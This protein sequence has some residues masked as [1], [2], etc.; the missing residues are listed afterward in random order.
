MSDPVNNFS[1]A[2]RFEEMLAQKYSKELAS[3]DLTDQGVS[4]VGAK[5]VKIPNAIMGGY[6]P[7]DRDGGF[8]RGSVTLSHTLK[9]LEYDRSVEFFVD[10]MDVDET[11]QAATA[12]KLTNVFL[13]EQ[14]I[15]ELDAYRF[16]TLH[17]RYVAADGRPDSTALTA[18]NVLLKFDQ[19]MEEMDEA[20]AP[21]DG[22]ILYV[23][24]R[25]NSL[26]KNAVGIYRTFGVQSGA[27]AVDRA[28]ASLDNVK[29]VSVPAGRMR[30]AYNFSDGFTPEGDQIN[31]ILLHPSA[32]IAVQK[33]SA[34]YLWP[35]GSHQRG[36]GWLYQNRR[37]GDLFIFNEKKDGI[38]MNVTASSPEPPEEPDQIVAYSLAA[39]GSDGVSTTE[40]AITLSE[41]VTLTLA[42]I[43]VKGYGDAGVTVGGLTG[44]D[45]SYV[46]GITTTQNDKKIEINI[47][48]VEGYEFI[49]S[50]NEVTV[51]YGI[52]PEPDEIVAFTASANG[53]S[54]AVATTAITVTLSEKVAGLTAAKFKL[55]SEAANTI[56]I[57]GATTADE[58]G[59]YTLAVTVAEDDDAKD[60]TLTIEDVTGYE[61][62][63]VGNVFKVYYHA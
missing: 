6:K 56:A 61:F 28:V 14:A 3:S 32:V 42:N 48:N 22:R 46:L 60:I 1:Y 24:P 44:S 2:T 15:P 26:I 34:I 35:A 27:G 38:K 41:A 37:Y 17:T 59:V 16:S 29:I 43:E 13:E 52:P 4:F 55:A 9:E 40:I 39:N 50:D 36:D 20:G 19:F 53:S 8:G 25:V 58:G 49:A 10:A 21:A 51:W 12:A 47:I 30:T 23:T 62:L 33:H 5:S 11:N 18:R 54:G 45:K 7:H 57:T 31:M 63:G